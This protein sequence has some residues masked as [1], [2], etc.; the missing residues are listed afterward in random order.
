MDSGI[1]KRHA[2]ATF[3]VSFPMRSDMYRPDGTTG[4]AVKTQMTIIQALT[5]LLVIMNL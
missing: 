4:R 3:L 1:V 2:L 5:R